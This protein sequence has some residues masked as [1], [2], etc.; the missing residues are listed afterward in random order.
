MMELLNLPRDDPPNSCNMNLYKS[1]GA[2]LGAHSDDE[3]IFDG[4][5]QP[6]TIVSFSLGQ[7]RTFQIVDMHQKHKVVKDIKL[8]SLAYYS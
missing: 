7:M 3:Q 1:G 5:N 2:K 8:P 4:K 6:I